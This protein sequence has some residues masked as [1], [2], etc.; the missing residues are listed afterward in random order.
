MVTAL[1][2]AAM[3]GIGAIIAF[4]VVE[5]IINSKEKLSD[6]YHPRQ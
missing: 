1:F 3:S 4:E 5:E 6:W 2:L